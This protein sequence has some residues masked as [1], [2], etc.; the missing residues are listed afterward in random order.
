MTGFRTKKRFGQHFLVDQM[1]LSSICECAGL[2]TGD[3]CIEI[4]PGQG[5]LTRYLLNTN[6]DVHAIEID[7][8]L[9]PVLE[10][11]KKQ[12]THFSY[13]LSDVLE[14][15]LSEILGASPV[16]VVGNLPYE[17]ST[18]LLFK[19]VEYRSR[20]KQMV[21]LLQKE[22]VERI[23]ASVGTK[24]YGR[25]AVMMQYY[26]SVE[27]LL[28][29]PPEAFS[30]PPKVMSQVVRLVPIERVWVDHEKLSIFVKMLFSQQRKMLRQRFKAFL[31][32]EDWD[33]LGI[34]SEMRPSQLPMNDILKLYDYLQ[35]QGRF[36][37]D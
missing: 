1:I 29:V 4:G 37:Q 33:L 3:K 14:V 13:T 7:Q 9:V 11:L 35:K 23:T 17:I 2:S 22:V 8:R 6:A 31:S 28:V 34:N 27:G 15:E 26:F 21:F 12:H 5:A 24:A 18:P 19:L 32:S 20:V 10:K 30:P 36:I 25:L 16:S